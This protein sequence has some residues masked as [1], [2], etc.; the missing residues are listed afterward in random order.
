MSGT[1]VTGGYRAPGGRSVSGR[2][3]PARP[4]RRRSRASASARTDASAVGRQRCRRSAAPAGRWLRRGAPRRSP[5]CARPRRAIS[6]PA[7]P[8][9]GSEPSRERD[10]AAECADDV[11]H[12]HDGKAWNRMS[13]DRQKRGPQHQ[14]V[15]TEVR[16]RPHQSP[17]PLAVEQ[18][19]LGGGDRFGERGDEARDLRVFRLQVP[20]VGR[21]A[22]RDQNCADD[23]G[24]GDDR[25]QQGQQQ[26]ALPGRGCRSPARGRIRPA[27]GHRL[28]C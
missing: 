26:V 22:P 2:V 12:H 10:R 3:S 5:R 28:R 4:F 24:C 1:A 19:P 9:D 13:S 7:I 20:A 6:I 25:R 18:D 15:E 14:D 17:D 11:G 27:P 8:P 23:S 21:R 16:Q